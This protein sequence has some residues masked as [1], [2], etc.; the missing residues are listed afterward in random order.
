MES[1]V[2]TLRC[3]LFMRIWKAMTR[4][5]CFSPENWKFLRIACIHYKRRV[6]SKWRRLCITFWKCCN[7][8]FDIYRCIQVT[9]SCKPNKRRKLLGHRQ[10]KRHFKACCNILHF[11]KT[12]VFIVLHVFY[13]FI[14][15]KPTKN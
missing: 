13:S 7:S 1:V 4:I 8:S 3:T 15:P 5:F 12:Q 2:K 6:Y 9:E 11:F 14:S 10:I